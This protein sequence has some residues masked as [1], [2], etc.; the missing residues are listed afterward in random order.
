MALRV[1]LL[2]IEKTSMS[3]K[4]D[5]IKHECFNCIMTHK[6]KYQNRKH[7]SKK[8]CKN[9]TNFVFNNQQPYYIGNIC[10]IPLNN[11]KCCDSQ[12]YDEGDE[13]F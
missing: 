5:H 10:N 11:N 9:L 7:Y 12:K 6:Q 8:C 3:K 4:I 2:K 1:E 13:V